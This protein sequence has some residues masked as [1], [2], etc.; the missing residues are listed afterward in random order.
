MLRAYSN[1]VMPFLQANLAMGMLILPLLVRSRGTPRFNRIVLF[2]LAAL[3]G[4]PIVLAL[5]LGAFPTQALNLL[6]NGTY[7]TNTDLM[8]AIA[9]HPVAS[10]AFVVFHTALQSHQKPQFVFYASAVAAF[11][12]LIIGWPLAETYGATG[13]AIGMAV[14]FTVNALVSAFF[15]WKIIW[16]AKFGRLTSLNKGRSEPG[17]TI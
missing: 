10:G 4:A 6:Y 16:S 9:I 8:W 11:A 3:S 12:A 13:A 15:C 5:I 14:A 2:G 1:L 7:P 17:D